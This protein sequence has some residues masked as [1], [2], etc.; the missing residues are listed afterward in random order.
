VDSVESRA[1][2]TIRL[3]GHDIFAG[4]EISGFLGKFREQNS[5]INVEEMW[6][7]W[8]LGRSNF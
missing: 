1:F 2:Y 6:R 8:I 5:S 3:S 4:L 7:F